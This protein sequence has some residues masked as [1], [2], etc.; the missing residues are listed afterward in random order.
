MFD[1]TIN[2]KVVEVVLDNGK[3]TKIDKKFLETS[4]EKL[5]IDI[6]E[7]IEMWLD[8]EGYLDNEEQNKL[9]SK[10]KANKVN[11]II[12]AK[13]EKPKKTQKE[14]VRK[15]NPTKEMIIREIAQ[16]LPQFATN[17]QVENV[18]KI[19]TFSIGDDNFKLDLTQTRK[20]KSV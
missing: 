4:C 20:K 7:A 18:G 16:V 3:K 14:R 13:S 11:K 9:D 5:G 8:D 19:I 10:A 17:V 15:E 2:E 1:Y 12:T 6:E